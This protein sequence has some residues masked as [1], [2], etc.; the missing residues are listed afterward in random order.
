M[1][2]NIQNEKIVNTVGGIPTTPV[3]PILVA[4]SAQGV[5]RVHLST[6]DEFE[7]EAIPKVQ[8]QSGKA[9]EIL[10]KTIQQIHEY[11]EGKRKSFEVPLDWSGLGAFAQ[12]VLQTTYK[13]HFGQISTYGSIARDI[14]N[15]KASRA[16]GG[17]LGRNPFTLIVP[18]HR[19]I[20]R[21]GSLQGFS[22]PGGLQTKIWL[23][24]FEGRKM[25]NGKVVL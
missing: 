10:N 24:E 12:C 9:K 5:T 11:F 8:I 6:M 14:G 17:A 23:L 25:K 21:D 13:I 20:A 19:V 3:G 16:V 4:A 7:S 2:S 15:A 22:S 18:C 1:K